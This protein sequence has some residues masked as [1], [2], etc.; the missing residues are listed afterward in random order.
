MQQGNAY[1]TGSSQPG[2]RVNQSLTDL[3]CHTDRENRDKDDEQSA[4]E[5]KVDVRHI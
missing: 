3:T 1:E 2:Y 5:K 4:I